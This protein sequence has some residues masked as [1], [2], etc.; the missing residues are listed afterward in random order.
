MS[1][2]MKPPRTMRPRIPTMTSASLSAGYIPEP[3]LVF[4]G[5]NLHVNPRSGIARYGPLSYSPRRSHPNQVR[6]G[7]I[8]SALTVTASTEWL[9]AMAAGVGGDENNPE[10]PGFE[11]DRGFFSELIFDT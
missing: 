4:G 1:T 11:K 10:F 5:S 7:V 8:G 9:R 6:V 2:T 3:L